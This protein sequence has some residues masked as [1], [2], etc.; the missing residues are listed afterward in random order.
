MPIDFQGAIPQRG[1]P[2]APR[3]N[4][5]PRPYFTLK[6]HPARWGLVGGR[7]RPILG[8]IRSDPGVGGVDKDGNTAYA[9][10]DAIGRRG[11]YPVRVDPAEYIRVYDGSRGP[12][13]LARWEVPKQIGNRTI[14]KV[15]EA[16]YHE[17]LDDLVARGLVQPMD[18][19]LLPALIDEAQARADRTEPVGGAR[20]RAAL[21][22]LEQ[23]QAAAAPE[24]PAARSSK[25]SK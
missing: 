15:D 24:A 18:P 8:Q 1:G 11:W 22:A 2:A 4:L 13:H 17:F 9:E 21:E 5:A 14:L 20:Y 19:D 7:I 23:V 16:S 25:A 3:L 10:A 6:H 12:V